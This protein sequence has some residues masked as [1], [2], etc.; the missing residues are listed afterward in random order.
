MVKKNGTPP[1]LAKEDG[2]ETIIAQLKDRLD[3]TEAKDV[4]HEGLIGL[5]PSITGKLE[6]KREFHKD[7]AS[8]IRDEVSGL[9]DALPEDENEEDEEPPTKRRV[10]TARPTTKSDHRGGNTR[11]NKEPMVEYGRRAFNKAGAKGL[12]KLETAEAIL[13]LGYETSQKDVAEFAK[14][15][16]VSCIFKMKKEL[17]LFKRKDGT[18]AYRLKKF[19]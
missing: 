8:T 10:A 1:E 19:K 16:Y 12:T 11:R 13:K 7:Q 4:P 3:N 5:L 14:S 9:R 6:E 17:V 15:V 18:R 2:L